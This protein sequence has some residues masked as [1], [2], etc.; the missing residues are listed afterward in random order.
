MNAI[1]IK[2]AKVLQEK[3]L[4]VQ[5]SFVGFA[6]KKFLITNQMLNVPIKKIF[7]KSHNKTQRQGRYERSAKNGGNLFFQEINKIKHGVKQNL[8][9]ISEV[10]NFKG[11]YMEIIKLDKHSEKCHPSQLQ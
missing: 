11:I 6:S 7:K 1:W 3:E 2:I 10:S 5:L 8:V 4:L 9:D